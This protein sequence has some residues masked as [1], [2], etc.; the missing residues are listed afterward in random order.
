MLRVMVISA[1]ILMQ[2]RTMKTSLW[3]S[4]IGS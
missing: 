2:P 4:Q 3:I 1:F